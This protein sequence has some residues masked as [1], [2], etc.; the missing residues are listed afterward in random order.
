MH[1]AGRRLAVL[2]AAIAAL[3][4]VLAVVLPFS[5][6]LAA[7]VSAA[8]NG[9]GASH[10]A[11]ILAVGSDRA[12][13]PVQGRGEDL[14]QA[15][16]VS[17]ACVA[18]EEAGAAVSPA[19]A[20]HFTRAQN[21]GSIMENGLRAGSYATP[22]GELSPLQ[23][24]IDLALPPNRGLPS[25]MLRVDVAGLRSAGYDIPEVSQVGRSFNMPGGG[26]EMQFPYPIPPEFLKVVWP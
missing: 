17:G 25:A 4:A 26:S 2:S 20:F 23:A 15:Q 11:M 14:P 7:A 22:N 18:A 12:V 24:Q 8:G 3:A 21:L 19:E 9:V 5:S 6:A 1:P 10:P 16:I 13:C